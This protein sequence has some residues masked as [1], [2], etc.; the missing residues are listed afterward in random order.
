MNCL[1]LLNWQMSQLD[2][3][4]SLSRTYAF[5]MDQLKQFETF[6]DNQK[7]HSCS[8]VNY[9]LDDSKVVAIFSVRMVQ[10]I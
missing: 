3:N 1:N 4:E 8:K 9:L 7:R 6:H 10:L 2:Q 5:F